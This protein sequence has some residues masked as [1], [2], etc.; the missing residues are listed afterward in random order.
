M[1]VKRLA[2]FSCPVMPV[3]EILGFYHIDNDVNTHI[4]NRPYA[5]S[6]SITTI[7]GYMHFL[8]PKEKD[9]GFIGMKHVDGISEDQKAD[10]RLLNAGWAFADAVLVLAHIF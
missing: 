3:E 5:W 2:E 8:E 7:D 6:N 9:V 1:K 10:W 4:K